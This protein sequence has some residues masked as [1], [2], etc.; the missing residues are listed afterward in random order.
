MEIYIKKNG[1]ELVEVLYNKFE[2]AGYKVYI[3][4]KKKHYKIEKMYQLKQRDS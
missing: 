2:E 1:K 3:D 4:E